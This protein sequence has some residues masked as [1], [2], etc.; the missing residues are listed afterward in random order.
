MNQKCSSTWKKGLKVIS[1]VLLLAAG[2]MLIKTYSSHSRIKLFG[3]SFLVVT[4]GSMEPVL[5]PGDLIIVQVQSEYRTGEIVTYPADGFLVT[6]RIKEIVDED[7][8]LQG[9]TNNAADPHP[10]PSE[11]ILGKVVLIVPWLGHAA[12]FLKTPA[13]FLSFLAAGFLMECGLSHLSKKRKGVS[14]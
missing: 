14:E 2:L 1:L 9:D 5:M 8:I 10:V 7:L 13:G 6:H 12:L 11:Q 4:S 3:Y